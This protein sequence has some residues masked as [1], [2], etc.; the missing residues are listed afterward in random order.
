M[1]CCCGSSF[2]CYILATM[3]LDRW[4]TKAKQGVSETSREELAQGTEMHQTLTGLPQFENLGT[5]R[6]GLLGDDQLEPLPSYKK[7]GDTVGLLET[8][9]MIYRTSRAFWGVDLLYVTILCNIAVLWSWI[10]V[11][12]TLNFIGREL[13]IEDHR[14]F[15]PDSSI[16]CIGVDQQG[17]ITAP[18][19]QERVDICHCPH[20][21][22]SLWWALWLAIMLCHTWLFFTKRVVERKTQSATTSALLYTQQTQA[23]GQSDSYGLGAWGQIDPRRFTFG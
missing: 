3:W 22:F 10:F 9:S 17:F 4:A 2:K 7:T 6:P 19:Y 20:H 5:L 13:G 11:E 21:L 18:L 15:T 23:A 12:A 1:W 14:L 16:H 8:S